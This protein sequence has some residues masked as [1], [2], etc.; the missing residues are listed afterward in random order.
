MFLRL[1]TGIILAAVV[2]LGIFFFPAYLLNAIIALLAATAAYECSRMIM[3]REPSSSLFF[4]ALLS[5]GLAAYIMFG[6]QNFSM[7]LWVLPAVLMVTLVFYLVKRSPLDLVL[8]QIARTVFTIL[9]VGLLFSF[10]GLLRNLPEGQA[11]LILVL[12]TTFAADTGAYFSGRYLGRHKLAPR[13]SPGKTVEGYFGG[14][15]V[16]VAMAFLVEYIIFNYFSIWDC[17]AVGALVGLLGPLGDLAESLLKR[18]VGAKDSGRLIPGHGG[19]LDRVD[20]L[21]FT[22][23][24]VYW[25]AAFVHP[26]LLAR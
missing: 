4:P 9:Y 6:P 12:S 13:V 26:V 17:L 22:G 21:L 5:G 23:P 19:V 3:P 2:V 10:L 20:A 8:P 24:L 7:V 1:F 25:Y 11:W 16:S 14:L 15:L 18:G